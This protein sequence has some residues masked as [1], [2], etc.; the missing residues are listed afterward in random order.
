MAHVVGPSNPATLDLGYLP[1]AFETTFLACRTF[2]LLR[3]NRGPRIVISCQFH[4]LDGAVW[5][6][7]L[8][9]PPSCPDAE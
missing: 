7:L 1:L 4:Q 3:V 5:G 2:E 8:A 6:N 9:T